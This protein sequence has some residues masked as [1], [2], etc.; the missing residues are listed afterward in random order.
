[1]YRDDR[2]GVVV[3]PHKADARRHE[4]EIG[5]GSGDQELEEGLGPA[6]I[7]GLA[8]AELHQPRQPVLGGLTQLAV[9]SESLALLENALASWSRASCGWIIT[10][11]PF[12]RRARIHK[13][14]NG[15]ASQMS[16]S[17][18]RNARK[19]MPGAP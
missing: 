11:L 15:Q 17:T 5:D 18:K 12:P 14:R 3:I 2:L 13:D 8:H 9:R 16:A 7:A 6:Q 1:M 4:R 19:G 10:T